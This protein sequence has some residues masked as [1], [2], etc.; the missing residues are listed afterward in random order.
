VPDIVEIDRSEDDE[1]ILMGCDGVW[2]KYA[3]NSKKMIALVSQLKGKLDNGKMVLDKLFG[4]LVAK[5]TK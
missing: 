1:Y 3:N 4:E 5:D 2:E